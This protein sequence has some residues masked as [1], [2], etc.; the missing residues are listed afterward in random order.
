VSRLLAE[1]AITE[2]ENVSDGQRLFLAGAVA[3]ADPDARGPRL[4]LQRVPEPKTA[5]NRVQL[6]VPVDD[7]QLDS[8]VER[9]RASGATLTGYNTYPGHRAAVM[10]DPEFCL[11]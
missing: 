2:A 5:R 6:D 9:L 4:Y 7:D 8:E 11:H 1:G 10:R 3:A